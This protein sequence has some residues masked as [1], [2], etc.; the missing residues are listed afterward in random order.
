MTSLL[1]RARQGNPLNELDLSDLHGHIGYFNFGIPDLS[2]DGMVAA[3]DRIGIA[4]IVC[5]HM[6]CMSADVAWGNDQVL[7]AMRRF[8]G[9]ILGYFSVWPASAAAVREETGR[10]L[11]HPFTGLKLHNV[12]AFSY[13]DP[14]YEPAY[15]ACARRC[16]PVLL[17]TWGEPR[18]FQA[19]RALTARYPGLSFL[20]AHAGSTHEA[21]YIAIARDCPNVYLDT[22]LS[23]S[24]RG[25][26]ERLA[27]GA[28]ADKVVWGSDSYFFSPAQQIGKVLGAALPDADKLKILSLN[29]RRILARILPA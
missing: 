8:P 17:H 3:M 16:M 23:A 1:E 5:S 10:C 2:L 6:R 24:P 22:A 7:L 19:V 27:R 15:E 20:L 21:D 18:E 25:L 13:D 12:N 26:I 9:R 14:A 29:A 28:G 11:A 4:R